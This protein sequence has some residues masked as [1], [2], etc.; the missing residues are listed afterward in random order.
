MQISYLLNKPNKLYD[1]FFIILVDLI[2][3]AE[4]KSRSLRGGTFSRYTFINLTTHL[5]CCFWYRHGVAVRRVPLQQIAARLLLLSSFPPPP[6]IPVSDPALACAD[7]PR[8]DTL[9]NGVRESERV[10]ERV[11]L[12]MWELHLLCKRE[13][14][15][16]CWAHILSFTGW[17]LAS[18]VSQ[19]SCQGNVCPT[20]VPPLPPLFFPPHL[21]TLSSP[22]AQP[23]PLLL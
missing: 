20:R 22:W 15:I 11:P 16:D 7:E 17:T 3:L 10:N 4:F 23:C 8:V 21:P 18:A 9:T 13:P 12:K 6:S 19:G 1:F 5:S 14:L 2:S